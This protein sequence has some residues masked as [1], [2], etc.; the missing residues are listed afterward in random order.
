MTPAQRMSHLFHT[1]KRTKQ[2]YHTQHTQKQSNPE[3]VRPLLHYW[4]PQLTFTPPGI[5]ALLH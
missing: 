1:L 4:S 2:C 5:S 3:Y